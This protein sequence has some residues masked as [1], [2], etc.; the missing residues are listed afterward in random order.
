MTGVPRKIAEHKLNGNPNLT[1]VCQK[2]RPMAPERSEWLRLEVDKL[3]QAN[4]LKEVQLLADIL[5]MFNSLRSINMKVNPT[6]CS[7]GEEEGK[8]LGHIVMPRGIKA[9][10]KKIE[11]VERI[12][13]P[14]SRKEVKCLI[15]KLAALTRFLLK[16]VERSLP[17][18]QT[19]KNSL[20]KSNFRWTEEAEKDFV[21]MKSLLKELPTLTAPIA[22]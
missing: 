10:P 11:V 19:L 18:F 6:K 9:N 5:E 15:G 16:S 13:S 2:K 17:F 12:N 4:I 20:K 3:F 22:G 7:F 8:F 14:K 21:K 1:P